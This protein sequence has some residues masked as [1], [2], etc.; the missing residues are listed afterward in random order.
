MT[1]CV[2]VEADASPSCS[3]STSTTLTLTSSSTSSYRKASLKM[4][5]CLLY[6]QRGTVLAS[7]R[8]TFKQDEPS[9]SA[10]REFQLEFRDLMQ[11]H[12]GKPS[13][14]THGNQESQES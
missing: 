14:R 5:T 1:Y 9:L 2:V 12:F 10:L 7:L 6:C 3:H 13:S 8:L 11:R 4:Q